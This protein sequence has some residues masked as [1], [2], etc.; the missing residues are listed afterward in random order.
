LSFPK[1]GHPACAWVSL[2]PLLVAVARV[3]DHAA[4]STGAR[5]LRRAFLLGLASGIVYFAGALYWLVDV[6]VIYGGLAQPVALAVAALLTV[7]LAVYPA[8]FA[9]IVG[10]C[11][12]RFGTWTLVLAPAVWVA[13]ELGRATLLTGFPWALLGA[14]QATVLPIAQLASATGV[15]GLSVIVALGGASIAMVAVARGRARVLA[16]VLTAAL[17]VAVAVWG[18][19]RM[20]TGNLTAQGTPVRVGIVQGNFSQDIKW[21]ASLVPVILDRYLRLSAETI[22]RG[23]QLVV[24]PESSVP[25]YFLGD[26]ARAE[27]IRQIARA[28][29][30][31]MLIGSDEYELDR[32]GPADR[33]AEVRFYNSAF[34]L[35]P[36]G[37]VDGVYRKMHL[38]PF[39]EY[40]PLKR[41]LFFVAPLVQAVSDFSAGDRP[42]L[43][44]VGARRASAA[45][46][47]EVIYP[48]LI[49]RFV[50]EGSELI[51]TITNDA[52]F[53]R[54]SAAYQHFEQASL[55][56]IEQG[57]YLV[58]AANT[59][60]SGVVDPYGRV[61]DR[62]PLFETVTVER[63]VRFLQGRT[64]YNRIG[65]A[66]AY[67]CLA[68]TAA[69]LA[70]LRR[71]RRAPGHSDST[72]RGTSALSA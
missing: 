57:R 7:Y 45:I 58:R 36:D 14:S 51:T 13:A 22:G 62:T 20:A 12:R 63:E 2:A 23:A 6:M 37:E 48:E 30:V 34:M 31:H 35:R 15:Y 3:G 49:G 59:G 1:F 16:P 38:V 66:V 11:V 21:E 39:G 9:L 44:P 40:V 26:P 71:A 27:S 72:A 50:R 52:W 42:A 55:R 65:D 25:F 32:R 5:P 47:Y 10:A 70:A 18:R 19:D 64:V 8:A 67:L 24:W 4:A 43:L 54:S 61:L 33:A 56:A 68:V 53:G 28:G 69:A 46:C 60:I 41:L 29:R 17:V